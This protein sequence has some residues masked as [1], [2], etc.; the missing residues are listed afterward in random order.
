[1]ELIRSIK[2][3]KYYLINP[4]LKAKMGIYKN[5]NGY[6]LR[7]CVTDTRYDAPHDY[8]SCFNINWL[9]DKELQDWLAHMIL[10]IIEDTLIKSQSIQRQRF[11]TFLSTFKK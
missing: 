10:S 1:M 8:I 4:Y 2:P 7:V 3:S 9:E 5:K 11:E 6:Q